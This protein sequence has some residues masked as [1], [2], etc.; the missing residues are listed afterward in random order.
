MKT[1]D[2]G[3]TWNNSGTL[4]GFPNFIHFADSN[5]GFV[6]CDANSMTSNFLIYRTTDGDQNWTVVPQANM[7]PTT[8]Y[9]FTVSSTNIEYFDSYQN[10]YWFATSTGKLYKSQNNGLNWSAIDTPYTTLGEATANSLGSFSWE[11]A[12]N[13]YLLNGTGEV[14]RTSNGGATWTSVTSPTSGG[15]NTNFIK[16]IPSSN[17][18]LFAG[19]SNSQYSTDNGVTWNVIE[20]N[21][22]KLLKSKGESLTFALGLQGEFYKL[23]MTIY[24]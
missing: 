19:Q 11:D 9:Q 10:N 16:K 6:I 3:I 20:N 14:Q 21:G 15:G 4:P 7:P 13:A 24:L 18:L 5:N 1:T 22:L 17:L 2:G 8:T 12:N 23:S